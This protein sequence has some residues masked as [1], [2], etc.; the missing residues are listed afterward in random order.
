M[1]RKRFRRNESVFLFLFYSSSVLLKLCFTWAFHPHRVNTGP[2]L[3]TTIGLFRCKAR[4]CVKNCTVK[5]QICFSTMVTFS[6][7]MVSKFC[8]RAVENT[9][10]VPSSVLAIPATVHCISALCLD[11]FVPL[12]NATIISALNTDILNIKRLIL[13]SRRDWVHY[14]K[15]Y[16]A[17]TE[18]AL[19]LTHVKA[20]WKTSGLIVL[21]RAVLK[22]C[23]YWTELWLIVTP[24]TV[25]CVFGFREY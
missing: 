15:F 6:S 1:P 16:C 5:V 22:D 20:F 8:Y 13:K 3:R 18:I 21:I 25:S 23:N 4:K 10:P 9:S 24:L 2:I 7:R 12:W 19:V 17:E 11:K 14:L